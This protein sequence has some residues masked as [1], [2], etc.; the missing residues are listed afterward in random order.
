MADSEFLCLGVL[1][2]FQGFHAVG[3]D[4]ANGEWARLVGPRFS[5]ELS[6][7]H[8]KV[9]G[10]GES[11]RMRPLD[12]V[13]VPLGA[14]VPKKHQPE[15]R[16]LDRKATDRPMPLLRNA[17]KERS[18]VKMIMDMAAASSKADLL[19]GSDETTN[20]DDK[21]ERLQAS[22]L[23]VHSKHLMWS[24][25]DEFRKG[26]FPELGQGPSLKGCFDFGKY[27]TRYRSEEH[28]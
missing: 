7:G 19:Y 11:R 9:E 14:G 1:R 17:A 16:I 12:V 4:L 27:P 8:L 10:L 2:H 13:L 18:L 25:T 26:R 3:I 6:L 23:V 20:P 15:N 28:T 21:T 24:K 22:L 5:S